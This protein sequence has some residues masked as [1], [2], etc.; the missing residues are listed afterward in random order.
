[1]ALDGR[2]RLATSCFGWV[3]VG[4]PRNKSVPFFAVACGRIRQ[5]PVGIGGSVYT[6]LATPQLLE[7]YFQRCLATATATAIDDPFELSFFA[8]LHLSN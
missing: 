7:E 4:W 1:M 6:P 8:L 3:F 5:S 2:T